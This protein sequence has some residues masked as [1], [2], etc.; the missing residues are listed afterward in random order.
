MRWLSISGEP[1]QVGS[2]TVTPVARLLAVGGS[3]GGFFWRFP[4]HVRVE[5][6]GQMEQ[7][8]IVDISRI[9][10]Y[11]LYALAAVLFIRLWRSA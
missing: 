3:S 2:V 4:T 10:I 5:R 9:A 8:P 1:V 11:A 7:L 6:A